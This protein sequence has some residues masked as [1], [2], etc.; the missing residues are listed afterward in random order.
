MA[1]GL[2]WREVAQTGAEEAGREERAPLGQSKM[3]EMRGYAGSVISSG[4]G[5][6]LA[7]TGADW[8]KSGGCASAPVT[9]PKGGDNWALTG[10]SQPTDAEWRSSA[11]HDLTGAFTPETAAM[12]ADAWITARDGLPKEPIRDHY[13]R[14]PHNGFRALLAHLMTEDPRA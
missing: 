8:R 5:A 11:L 1:H 12:I 3:A 4:T 10:A 13:R 14:V 6:T 9:P 7:Q 2:N